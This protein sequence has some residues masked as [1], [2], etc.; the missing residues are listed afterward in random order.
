MS[1]LITVIVIKP[2]THWCEGH[3]WTPFSHLS[4]WSTI[5]LA[6]WGSISSYRPSVYAELS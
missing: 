1:L 3:I 5:C 2:R 6:Q 4:E